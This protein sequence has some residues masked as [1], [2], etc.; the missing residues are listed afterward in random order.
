M[1]LLAVLE[2]S[3]SLSESVGLFCTGDLNP[4][5]MASLKAQPLDSLLASASRHPPSCT[6]SKG[7]SGERGHITACSKCL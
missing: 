2:V 7:F 1:S 4:D 5:H 3:S 6:P